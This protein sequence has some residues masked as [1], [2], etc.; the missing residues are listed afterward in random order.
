MDEFDLRGAADTRDLCPERLR[1]LH[2]KGADA[3]SRADD[4]HTLPQLRRS[5]TQ[6][7]LS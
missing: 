5:G 6:R 7:A 4:E 1:Q 2:R 3:A